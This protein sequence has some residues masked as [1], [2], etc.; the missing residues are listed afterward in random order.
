MRDMAK[1]LAAN[2]YTVLVPNPYYR[3]TKAPGLPSTLDFTSADDRA[4]IAKVREL[5]SSFVK[6]S[7]GPLPRTAL[8]KRGAFGPLSRTADD[9]EHFSDGGFRIGQRQAVNT[10][11]A[12]AQFVLS[13]QLRHSILQV[14][15]S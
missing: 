4:K 1:R 9:R 7:P 11:A 10:V 15:H 12:D 6:H 5:L 8:G 2:G 3:T 13:E 14:T